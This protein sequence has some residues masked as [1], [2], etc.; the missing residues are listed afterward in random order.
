MVE[1]I[2]HLSVHITKIAQQSCI[3]RFSRISLSFALCLSPLLGM[4][5]HFIKMFVLIFIHLHLHMSI[6]LYTYILYYNSHTKES[7][8]AIFVA[9]SRIFH[10]T[11]SINVKFRF[12][13]ILPFF[14]YIL[15]SW[16]PCQINHFI[17]SDQ[18]SSINF[19]SYKM[20]LFC[21]LRINIFWH[22][23]LVFVYIF[24]SFAVLRW[25]KTDMFLLYYYFRIIDFCV[26][27]L[28]S[29]FPQS[30]DVRSL[31]AIFLSYWI[32]ITVIL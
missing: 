16:W 8:Y 11:S 30:L 15:N 1:L 3:Y 25:T 29:I 24:L 21:Y 28:I 14:W 10:A 26:L 12:T 9:L 2:A 32:F 13:S 27:F 19:V 5:L 18:N 20:F 4:N 7:F 22:V 17:I 6:Y 31:F 23:C